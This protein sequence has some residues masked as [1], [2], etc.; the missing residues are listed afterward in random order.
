[1]YRAY[2]P[3]LGRWPSRDPIEEDGGINLYAYV[4]N[5]PLSWVDLLGLVLSPAEVRNI[6]FNETRSLLGPNI[7]FARLTVAHAIIN[8]DRQFGNKRPKTAPT[9]AK[10]GP[11]E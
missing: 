6:V 8:G 1:M 2:D 11:T 7:D 4:K 5:S 3:E 9:T 10:P